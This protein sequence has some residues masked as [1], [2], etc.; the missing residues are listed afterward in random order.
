MSI[1]SIYPRKTMKNR[2]RLQ[3]MAGPHKY[4]QKAEKSEDG[5]LVS[6]YMCSPESAAEEFEI[7]GAFSFGY[8]TSC[9][10][11]S[12]IGEVKNAVIEISSPS[13]SF[14]SVE[15]VMLL[16][17]PLTKLLSVDCVTPLLMHNLFSEI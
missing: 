1:S 10:K 16:L 11:S 6:S 12:N 7:T 4:D 3:S 2:T 5:E 9:S 13:H 14:F 8:M 15:S 17:R